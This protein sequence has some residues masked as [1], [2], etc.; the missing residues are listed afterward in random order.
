MTFIRVRSL[1]YESNK[2]RG[3]TSIATTIVSRLGSNVNR[4]KTYR[5]MMQEKPVPKIALIV[6]VSLAIR[7]NLSTAFTTRFMHPLRGFQY[8]IIYSL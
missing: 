8:S 1:N 4:T 2:S 7:V 6:H 5:S 3:A